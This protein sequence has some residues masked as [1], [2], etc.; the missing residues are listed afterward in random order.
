VY[1][2]ILSIASALLLGFSGTFLDWWGWGWSILFSLILAVV[3]WAIVARRIAAKLQPAMSRVQAQMQAGHVD[4][5]MQSLED[6]L[7]MG[8]WMPMLRG[9]LLANMGMIAWH[10]GKKERALD[11]LEKSSLRAPDARLLL[12]C[13]L[14]KNGDSARALH[15][16]QV[17]ALVNKKHS[18]LHNTWAW[19]L[20]KSERA[21]EAQKVLADFVKKSP[22]DEAAKDNL[23]RLQ[24]R[25]RMNM[26]GFGMHWFALGLEQP[27]QQMGQMRRA[28]NGFREP[29]KGKR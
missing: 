12:G 4:A 10:S 6:L 24:N 25:S 1:S 23:L 19:I 5:A 2:V 20:H 17:A 16:L 9:Q 18:L 21:D 13:I 11:L 3:I 29:P 7:P 14:F 8:K 22:N 15:V 27:P 28:P 26:Q